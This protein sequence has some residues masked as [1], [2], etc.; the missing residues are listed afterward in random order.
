VLADELSES[1]RQYQREGTRS[2]V[3]SGKTT[4]PTPKEFE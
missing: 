3:R 2:R 1:D 4:E